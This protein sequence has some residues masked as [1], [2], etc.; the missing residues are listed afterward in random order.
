MKRVS[1]WNSYKGVGSQSC[2]KLWNSIILFEY[3]YSTSLYF[4]IKVNI[5][6]LN[7]NPLKAEFSLPHLCIPYSTQGAQWVSMN[8]DWWL[9]TLL[10][11]AAVKAPIGMST[12]RYLH[13][14]RLTTWANHSHIQES[15]A[16]T[17]VWESSL[18]HESTCL[19]FS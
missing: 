13:A 3:S 19:L 2:W 11:A 9:V 4:T 15:E 5:K 8:I 12:S 14:L 18:I 17:E 16:S 6:H 1:C 10:S 7:R